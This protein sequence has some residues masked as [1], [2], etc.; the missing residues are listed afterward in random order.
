MVNRFGHRAGYLLSLLAAASCMAGCI[1]RPAE[2]CP[3]PEPEPTPSPSP[4]A[5]ISYTVE[6]RR[7][8]TVLAT[9][10]VYAGEVPS[11]VPT[12]Q[13]ME[14]LG[15]ETEAGESASPES[16]PVTGNTVYYAV[17]RPVLHTEADWLFPD[18]RGFLRPDDPFTTHQA[19]QALRAL[20]NETALPTSLVSSW[21]AGED[22][23]LTEEE[24]QSF[25]GALFT[26][27]ELDSLSELPPEAEGAPTRAAAA[28]WV[29]T[30]T[31][32]APKDGRY[33]PDVAPAYWAGDALLAAAGPG[34]LDKDT[35]TAQALEGF[36]WFDG[37][38]YR[39][40]DEGYLITGQTLDG[41]TYTGTGQYTSGTAELDDY[42]AGVLRNYVAAYKTRQEIL[43]EVY[44]YVRDGFHYLARNYYGFGET[45]WDTQE[46][47]TM[48]ETGKGNCYNYAAVFC[49]LARGLG[50][51]ATPYSGTMGIHNQQHAWTEITLDGQVYVCDPEI[52][53]NYWY[54]GNYTDNFMVPWT[55]ALNWLNYQTIRE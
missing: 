31:D 22:V 45:G 30:L 26:R 41:L 55:D 25:L 20:L 14:L 40:D 5:A 2:A 29:A 27:E 18:D 24:F 12:V 48:F 36:L 7:G 33:F 53:L 11:A 3:S 8:D 19:A 4:T 46:A 43:R 35:F 6:F 1:M 23:P 51:N 39:L 50:Y 16:D 17:I 42:V 13:D 9:E 32:A 44:L 15:W 34:T 28:W 47:L 52:E 54:L 10:S 38:L 21:E 37:Y 49:S